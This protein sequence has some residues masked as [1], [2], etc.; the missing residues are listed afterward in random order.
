MARIDYPA[1]VGVGLQFATVAPID[2]ANLCDDSLLKFLGNAAMN[3]N[4]IGRDA[5]LSVVREFT[6]NDTLYRLAHIRPGADNGRRLPAQFKRYRREIAPRCC[7]DNLADRR[8]A[9][10]EDMIERLLQ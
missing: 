7:H 6:P 8:T 4:M 2:P 10:E 5:G 3:V 1:I 9:G